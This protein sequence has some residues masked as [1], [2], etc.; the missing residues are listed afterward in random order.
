MMAGD[1]PNIAWTPMTSVKNADPKT[2][3]I[4]NVMKNIVGPFSIEPVLR[5]TQ[6]STLRTK[7][8]M[9]SVHPTQT[10]KIHTAVSPL[11]AFTTATLNASKI[12]PMMSLPTPADMTTIPTVVSSSLS[13]VRTRHN[14]GNAVIEYATPVKSMKVMYDTWDV[15]AN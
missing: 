2:I 6:K 12:H 15:S 3:R 8:S 9:K 11:P 7:N 10:N 14:S 1:I 5:A 13:S 4:V